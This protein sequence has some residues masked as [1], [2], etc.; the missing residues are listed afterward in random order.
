MSHSQGPEEGIILDHFRNKRGTFLD[1][2]A[3]DGKT[4]SNTHAL[5]LRG[6]A[7]VCIEPSPVAFA[8]LKKTYKN[9]DKIELINAAINNVDG[10]CTLHQASYTLVS[11]LDSGNIDRWSSYNFSWDPVEVSGMTFAM[12]MANSPSP[13][14]EFVNIDAEGMCIDILK[15]MNL[16]QLGCKLLC[17]EHDNRQHEIL[18]LCKGWKLVDGGDINLI[19][20]R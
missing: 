15:Q 6:W 7:G 11:S 1:I 9:N 10:P 8:S 12:F 2:G 4:F 19:L 18:D 13:T 16:Q 3:N 5:A 17:I 14:F 20:A